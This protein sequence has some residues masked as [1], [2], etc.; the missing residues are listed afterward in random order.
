MESTPKLAFSPHLEKYLPPDMWRE[1]TAG[2]PGRKLL[3]EA[4]ARLHS[5]LYLLST[6]IPSH[7]FQEKLREPL[8]G[9]VQGRMLNGSLL[10]SDVS[11]FTALSERLALAYA[12]EPQRGA[13][14]VTHIINQYFD[15]ML[16]ILAW[17]GGILLKFAGDA[18]LVYFPDQAERRLLGGGRSGGQAAWVV[19]A[20]QRMMRAMERFA[21]IETPVGEVPLKMKIGISTGRFAAISAGSARRMEYVVMG[22]AVVRAMAAEGEAQAGQVIV[23]QATANGFGLSFCTP[24]QLAGTPGQSPFYVVERA[25]GEENG[26]F[27]L[28]SSHHRASVTL[29]FGLGVEEVVAELERVLDQIEAVWPYL[30]PELA[31]RIVARADQRWLGGEYRPT[32]VLFMNFSGFEELLSAWDVVGEGGESARP[33]LPAA[34]DGVHTVARM[35]SEYFNTINQAIASFGGIVSRIDPYKHGSKLLALFGAPVA[36]EDDPLRAVHAALAMRAELA[37]LNGRWIRMWGDAVSPSEVTGGLIQQRIGIS[38]GVTFAGQ[39]GSSTRREYTVMG[40]EVNL[41]ARL[42]SAAQPD[43]I[44]LSHPVY[45][46]AAGHFRITPLPAIRVKGKSQPVS[47]YQVEGLRDDRLA[48]RLQAGG[49]LVGR[50]T[51]LKRGRRILRQALRGRGTLLTIRGSAGV[52]KSRLADALLSEALKRGARAFLSECES[53]RA[54][55]PYAPWTMLLHTIAGCS[56]ADT[57]AAR[58]EKLVRL[59]AE[60]GQDDRLLPLFDMLGLPAPPRRISARLDLARP[61]APESK[62]ADP[63]EAK[64]KPS[65]FG[66]IGQKVVAERP[67]AEAGQPS[68]A[69]RPVSLWQRAGQRHARAARS[70]QLWKRLETRVAAR[71]QARLF[72]AVRLLLE[73]LSSQTPL[74]ICFENAQWMDPVSRSL[75]HYLL[76]HVG[77]LPILILLVQRDEEAQRPPGARAPGDLGKVMSLSPLEPA[78][79]S[80]LVAHLLGKMA[81]QVD[82]PSLAEAV[83]EQSG[84]N[85]LFAEEIVRWLLRR[86]DALIAWHAAGLGAGLRASGTLRELVLSRVDSLPHA[87]REAARAASVVGDEF[88]TGELA[89]LVEGSLAELASGLEQARLVFMTEAGL[90]LHYA[91]RQTLVRE[92][93]YDSQSFARRQE[94][95][96]QL[97][98]YL[99]TRWAGDLEGQAELLAHHYEQAALWLPAARY[100]LVAGRKARQCYAYAEAMNCYDRALSGLDK[101]PPRQ[102]TA[103]VQQLKSQAHEG[104]GDVAVLSGEMAVAAAAYRTARDLLKERP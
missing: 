84:G 97:A 42:M 66:R 11:G 4:L 22:E 65:L 80:A 46:A 81:A 35:L 7:L 59:L 71:E 72:E 60:L 36:H 68:S 101:I 102:V 57:P 58:R 88:S 44:L 9:L 92:L 93:V 70:G 89:P 8:P 50:K 5:V 23:D 95:H 86:E 28:T 29:P 96:A 62:K 33:N 76:E 100:L 87:Q 75:L 41:A 53:Y 6:Y 37:A 104:R 69:G 78:G 55:L 15:Q 73:R 1:L 82:L 26:A 40:D 74:V 12:D 2:A 10:F 77:A 24:C 103:E 30:S 85:P 67:Q 52:G 54:A 20:A 14:Q 48:R 3:L 17:S 34:G 94:L 21:T 51:E 19:R 90:D 61:I 25:P 98:A 49:A 43:Q 56:T 99:E 63:L 91:F 32:T 45:E 16:E 31:E 18:L 39:A 27:D 47:I 79:V 64:A 83:Y 38:Q 13:E